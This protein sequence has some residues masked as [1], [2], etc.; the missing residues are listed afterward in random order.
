MHNYA[1]HK[2]PEVKDWLATH[3]RFQVHFTPPPDLG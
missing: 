1:T 2:T 3:P